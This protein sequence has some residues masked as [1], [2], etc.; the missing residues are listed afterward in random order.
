MELCL[1]L[2]MSWDF[3]LLFWSIRNLEVIT[4]FSQTKSWTNWKWTTLIRSIR[5]EITRQTAV[6]QI[7]ETESRYRES[8]VNRIET[9]KQKFPQELVST[10]GDLNYNCWIAEAH[11]GPAW[12]LKSS[13][14]GAGLKEGPACLYE[15]CS[16]SIC[17][18]TLSASHSE[19]QVKIPLCTERGGG[20]NYSETYLEHSILLIKS[21]PWG[22]FY[23]A[24]TTLKAGNHPAPTL[25]SFP[26]SLKKGKTTKKW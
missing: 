11:C 1:Y 22:K 10:E 18:E 8:Q 2:K 24:P 25:S 14:G 7:R 13:V 12:E 19:D 23:H 4:P 9:W 26:V 16:Q 17:T 3:W 20:S 21:C 15:F 5:D 6:P